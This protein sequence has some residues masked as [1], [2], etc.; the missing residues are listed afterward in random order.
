MDIGRQHGKSINRRAF[1]A[2]L[3]TP[4]KR[5]EPAVM[6]LWP[7]TV[8]CDEQAGTRSGEAQH[9]KSIARRDR[10]EKASQQATENSVCTG[11]VQTCQ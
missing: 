11:P 5:R 4:R 10:P 9:E 1:Q 7:G 3:L 8:P 6:R 2:L